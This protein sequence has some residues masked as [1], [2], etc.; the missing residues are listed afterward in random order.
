MHQVVI[1]LERR[2]FGQTM[3]RDAWWA[4][5]LLTFTKPPDMT[6][7]LCRQHI[8]LATSFQLPADIQNQSTATTLP[9]GG[10]VGRAA[11]SWKLIAGSGLYST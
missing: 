7:E 3:R 6:A 9:A 8:T 11:G 10:T 1:P 5:P 4:Q 2:G